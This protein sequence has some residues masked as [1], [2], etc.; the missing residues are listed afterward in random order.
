MTFA[1]DRMALGLL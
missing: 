1:F